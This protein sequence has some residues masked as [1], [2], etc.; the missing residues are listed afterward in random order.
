LVLSHVLGCSQD[1]LTLAAGVGERILRIPR[2]ED[3]K[4]LFMDFVRD[5]KSKFPDDHSLLLNLFNLFQSHQLN[6]SFNNFETKF[7][8]NLALKRI[9]KVRD[10]LESQLK[11]L[12][13]F[14]CEPQAHANSSNI[15][16][17]FL[18]SAFYPDI[19]FKMS[20]RNQYLLPGA[21]SAELQK[22]SMQFAQSLETIIYESLNNPETSCNQI[23]KSCDKGQ[24]LVYEELFDAGHTL[25][26]KSSLVDP[27][28][29]ALFADNVAVL[30][31]TIY[32]D[33]WIR[34]TSDDSESLKLLIE[35]RNL[36][37]SF[38]RMSLKFNNPEV[39]P[40][41]QKL[42]NALANIWDTQRHVE[43]K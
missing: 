37:K 31:K 42:L 33:N 14:N 11:Q 13:P 40:K 28:L 6:R 7:I 9:S 12:V 20:K 2:F 25:I 16:K 30:Y 34:I 23:I 35:A 3:E 17:L 1:V 32:V 39:Y 10:S 24:A 41:F 5:L 22:E 27:A 8:S 36:W 18:L 38:A 4:E 19:A 29:C 26:V 21:I 15:P 43:I